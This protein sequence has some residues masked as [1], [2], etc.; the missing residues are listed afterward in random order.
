MKENGKSVRKNFAHSYVLKVIFV[1]VLLLFFLIPFSLIRFM[2]NERQMRSFEAEQ[3]IVNLW[4]GQQTIA[5][6]FIQVPF[7][8]TI[9]EQTENGNIRREVVSLFI[10]TPETLDIAA[11]MKSEIRKR[12][13]YEIPVYHSVLKL[14][15]TFTLPDISGI[16]VVEENVLWDD[17]RFVVELPDMRAIQAGTYGTWNGERKKFQADASETDIFYSNLQSPLP[18]G[19]YEE[20]ENTYQVNLKLRGA[21]SLFFVPFGKDTDVYLSSDWPAPSFTGAFLP[22][23]REIDETGFTSSWA[24]HALARNFPSVWKI[25]DWASSSVLSSSFGV[26]LFEPVD[27]YTKVERSVKYGILFILLPFVAFFMF[28]VFSKKRIHI[29]QYLMVGAANT[30]FYLLLLSLSEHIGFNFSYFVSAAITSVLIVFYSSAVLSTKR[31]GLV[32]LP[33]MVG[34]YTFL[35]TI[36]QSEDYALLIGSVGLF[37]LMALVMIFTRKVDWHTINQKRINTVLQ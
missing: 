2:V 4:G 19:W 24:V 8:K 17:A 14:S 10:I 11:N 18:R 7:I 3:E 29:L 35:Y 34:L 37:I 20:E 9:V 25:E 16:H 13:I 31:Q 5:G 23:T 12:G 33:I 22:S 21:S 6:P 30:I 26:E 15:G 1:V 36:L 32:M 27:L 28:E